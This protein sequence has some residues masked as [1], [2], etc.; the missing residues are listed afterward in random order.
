MRSG[1]VMA[2]WNTLG[3]AAGFTD[4]STTDILGSTLGISFNVTA[5]APSVSLIASVTSGSWT[6]KVGTRVIF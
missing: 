6:V 1:T 4:Y 3:T 5:A 2:V